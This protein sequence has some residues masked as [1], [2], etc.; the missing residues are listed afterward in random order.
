MGNK[1]MH[2]A[3]E[4]SILIGIVFEIG[5]AFLLALDAIGMERI[6]SWRVNYLQDSYR[7]LFRY[8]VRGQKLKGRQLP[9]A[10][11]VLNRRAFRVGLVVYAVCFFVSIFRAKQ[12]GV[13]SD[14]PPWLAILMTII[15]AWLWGSFILFLITFAFRVLGRFVEWGERQ[16]N[17]GLASAAGFS[18]LLVGFLFQLVGTIMAFGD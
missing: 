16:S 17:R 14:F 15:V 1:T 5:G 18:V 10:D 7:I 4:L 9:H 2:F 6:K 13:L 3:S 12:L 11:P 8:Y